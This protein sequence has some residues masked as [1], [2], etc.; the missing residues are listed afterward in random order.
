MRLFCLFLTTST[1]AAPVDFVREVQPIFVKHCHECHGEKKQ[2]SG[3]RLDIKS[4]ALKGGDNHSPD[5][6]P[7]K[8]SESPLVHFLVSDDEDEVMPPKGKLAAAEIEVLT[9]WINEGTSWPEGV[10]KAKLEDKRD[11]WSFKPL[12]RSDGFQPSSTAESCHSLDA[13]IDANE[14]KRPPSFPRS[15]SRVLATARD[16]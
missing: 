13:F 16:F 11:H 4:E 15:R 8:A 12:A 5:I 1:L 2:K 7:G 6:V 10:D 3:L 9:R 14:R